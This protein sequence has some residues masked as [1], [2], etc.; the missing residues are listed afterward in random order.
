MRWNWDNI[1]LKRFGSRKKNMSQRN[2]L[3]VTNLNN[4]MLKKGFIKKIIITIN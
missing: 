3:L 2:V 4:C 1:D